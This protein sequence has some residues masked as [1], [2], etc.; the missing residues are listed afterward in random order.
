MAPRPSRIC[1]R[2]P[3]GLLSNLR[4]PCSSWTSLSEPR[5]TPTSGLFPPMECYFLPSD[6]HMACSLLRSAQCHP[7]SEPSL[8]TLFKTT[9]NPLPSTPKTSF[10]LY[11]FPVGRRMEEDTSLPVIHI[12]I[13]HH[14]TLFLPYLLSLG[15]KLLQ[16]KDFSVFVHCC[17]PRSWTTHLVAAQ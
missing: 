5:H 11:S 10:W 2:T 17:I 1:T 8:I 7:Y 12:D 4:S 3:S 15:C 9:A 13:P 16:S 6:V 14:P